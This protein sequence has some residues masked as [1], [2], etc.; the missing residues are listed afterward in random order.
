MMESS[1]LIERDLDARRPTGD[2]GTFAATLTEHSEFATHVDVTRR[3]AI[4]A[5]SIHFVRFGSGDVTN[6]FATGSQS[7]AA[8]LCRAI[9]RSAQTYTGI[10]AWTGQDSVFETKFTI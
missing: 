4:R 8:D 7:F 2:L 1:R 10:V 3:G 9:R 5:A 6:T